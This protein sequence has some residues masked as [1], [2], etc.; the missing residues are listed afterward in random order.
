MTD[1]KQA[2]TNAEA[3]AKAQKMKASEMSKA[4]LE[5]VDLLTEHKLE[6]LEFD[7]TL[8]CTIEDDTNKKK[9]E[10]IVTDG[11]TSFTAYSD[12]TI[13][14]NGLRVYVTVPNGDFNNKKIITGRYIDS[15]NSEYYTYKPPFEDYLDMSGNLI[16]DNVEKTFKTFSD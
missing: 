2:A 3:L 12:I 9:G 7:K 13:Y 8:V 1:K 14:M 5:A 4:I 6:R 16:K 10:Y 15:E 11:S